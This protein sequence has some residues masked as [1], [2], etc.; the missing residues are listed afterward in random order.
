MSHKIMIYKKDY[1]EN[2]PFYL[3]NNGPTRCSSYHIIHDK[4]GCKSKRCNKVI[5]LGQV[6]Y[7]KDCECDKNE[8]YCSDECCWSKCIGCKR[9]ICT[10]CYMYRNMNCVYCAHKGEKCEC[11]S[12]EFF[13]G[14][15][16]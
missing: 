16:E 14:S 3:W 6:V 7:Y 5:S 2:K 1:Q 15:G 13:C 9:K 4:F 11:D 8:P 12:E 10:R